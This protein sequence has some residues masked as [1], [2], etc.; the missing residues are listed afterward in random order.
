M[1]PQLIQLTR[2][3]LYEKVWTTPIQK[4]AKE[5]GLSDVGLAKLCRCH[6]IPVPGRGYW[7]RLAAGQNLPRTP[8]PRIE[9]QR[10]DT[11]EIYPR[12][13]QAVAND[14]PGQDQQVPTIEVAEDRPISHRLALRIERSISRSRKDRGV[15]LARK[16]R[17]VP[18]HVSLETRPRALRILDALL[19]AVEEAGHT[20]EWSKPYNTPLKVRVL[21]E[22]LE[23]SISEV[24]RAKPHTL[25]PQE[26]TRPWMAPKSD[27]EPTSRLKLSIDC[28]DYLGVRRA[29]SDGKRRRIEKCLG[30]FLV[31]LP[32]VANALKA[33]RA[34]R[35][36]RER[37]WAEE[38]KREEEA[39]K[40]REEY[41]RKAQVITKLAQAW[42]ESNLLRDFSAA[43]AAAAEKLG[44]TEQEKQE[45]RTM[46]SW[47]QAH[48]DYVDPLTDLKCA[49]RQFKNPPW[50]YGY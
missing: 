44:T 48:A 10:L 25:T 33:L 24:V 42:K 38:R 6:E 32:L 21:E 46:V 50:Q 5:F 9:D 8:L 31:T 47:T 18:I 34:E 7:A 1:H 15:L 22:A 45:T 26:S 2:T 20:L 27:Y 19:F 40:R 3:E 23:F 12:E 29:W 13:H 35:A 14:Q 17:A 4:L 43:L 37:K 11:I 49:I 39:R 16:G 30:H 41:A 36:E 28:S